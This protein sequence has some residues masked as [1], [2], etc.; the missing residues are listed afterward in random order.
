MAI[1]PYMHYEPTVSAATLLMT[2]W[3]DTS[4]DTLQAADEPYQRHRN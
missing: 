3:F 4:Q 2:E 1:L